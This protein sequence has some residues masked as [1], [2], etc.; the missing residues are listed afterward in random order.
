MQDLEID[1][2]QLHSELAEAALGAL[3]VAGHASDKLMS[4]NH[5]LRADNNAL[6]CLVEALERNN[7]DLPHFADLRREN[8]DLVSMATDA[9]GELAKSAEWNA[10]LVTKPQ[11][12]AEFVKTVDDLTEHNATVREEL[13]FYDPLRD[14]L[15]SKSGSGF[16]IGL[17]NESLETLRR[18][19]DH[20]LSQN[21]KFRKRLRTESDPELGRAQAANEQLKAELER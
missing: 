6:C 21:G 13:E 12:N 2:N 15:K 18:V 4:L 10:R 16:G 19:H 14:E 7:V 11:G 17:A 9:R 8:Q 20:V 5:S 1:V 3:V